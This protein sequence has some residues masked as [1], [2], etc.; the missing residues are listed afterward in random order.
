MLRDGLTGDWIGTFIGHKGAVWSA[1]LSSDA[2][3]AATGSADFTA[4]VW[5]TFTGEQLLDLAHNHIVRAVAFPGTPGRA[6]K[7]A[8]GGMEKRLRMWDLG[9]LSQG[10]ASNGVNGHADAGAQEVGAGVHG[11]SIK[12]IVWSR[13]A[14]VLTTAC[15]DKKIRWWDLRTANAPIASH[16]VDG[17]IGSCE[18]NE[19]LD[20]MQDGVLSVA[21]GKSVYFFD[22][23]RPGE[24]VKHVKLN[25]EAASVAVNGSARR[26]VTGGSGDTWVHVWDYDTETEV[27]EYNYAF[28][29]LR[30]EVADYG[31]V[32]GNLADTN[33][34]KPAKVIT[35]PYGQSLSHQ[36]ASFTQQAVKTAPSSCGKRPRRHMGFGG[37]ACS[38]DP[39]LDISHKPSDSERRCR[40]TAP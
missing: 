5:D 7:L 1:R 22:G 28:E 12:S 21:A 20:G 17:L 26:F 31:Y 15:D 33:P 14:N 37:D 2:S 16:D 38:H 9:S 25:T 18:L 27:G 19:G 10:R 36:T 29:D 35:G 30:D 23:G 4:K 32:I 13:D 40:L 34:Q 39:H 11:A 24:L 8:T 6:D 3:L